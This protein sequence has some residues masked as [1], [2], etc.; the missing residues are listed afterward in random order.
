MIQYNKTWVWR[1]MKPY[2]RSPFGFA[3]AVTVEHT[4]RFG[5]E[6]MQPLQ[7]NHPL[8]IFLRVKIK[9]NGQF[10]S[11]L[12]GGLYAITFIYIIFLC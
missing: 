12:N 3:P 9:E 2:K 4:T 7:N 8:T 11:T 10:P 5:S 6:A 1:C